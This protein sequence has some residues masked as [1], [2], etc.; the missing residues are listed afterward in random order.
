MA[1]ASTMCS[2]TKWRD[3]PALRLENGAV[4]LAAM[5]GGGA[6]ADFH[7]ASGRSELRTNVLWEAPWPMLDPDRYVAKSH[8]RMYSAES[9]GKFLAAFTGHVLCLDYFGAPSESEAH[10]GLCLHGEA[11]VN[12]W[13]V[14]RHS[15]SKRSVTVLMGTDLPKAGLRFQRRFHMRSGEPVVFV[16]ETV[17]NLRSTDHFFHWTQHVTLGPPFLQPGKSVICLPARR[18]VSWPHGYEGKSLLADSKEFTWPH[19][20][21]ADGGVVDISRPFLRRGTGFVAAAL[22]DPKRDWTFAAALNF[23]LGLLLGYCFRREAF[24]WVAVWEENCAR[25]TSPWNGSTQ[26]RGVEFGTTPMPVGRHEAF[27]RGPLFDTPTFRCVPA[28]GKV[29]TSYVI[30]LTPVHSDWR[31]IVDIQP[32]EREINVLGPKGESV[33][34]P[35][36]DITSKLAWAERT[37]G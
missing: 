21:G 17:A 35:A 22:L 14:L 36:K 30:F 5:V 25:E 12:R 34:V 31:E 24:P 37:T 11:S 13:K 2:K 29:Q 10:E 3:R 6:I 9:V 4:E 33:H 23:R 15:Q 18:A 27:A 26:A 28:K 20:P 7:L 32:G 8:D 16:S 19:A 1:S